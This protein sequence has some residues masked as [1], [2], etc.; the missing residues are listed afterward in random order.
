MS[1]I[2]DGYELFQGDILMTDDIRD[3][4]RDMGLFP[5]R[6]STTSP[7]RRKRAAISNIARRWIGSNNKPEIPY[8]LESSVRK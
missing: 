1:L 3:E 7:S 4:L 8:Q 5:L 6:D 2:S